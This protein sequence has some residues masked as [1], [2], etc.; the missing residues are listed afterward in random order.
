MSSEERYGIRKQPEES[1]PLIDSGLI[2]IRK[3]NDV[4]E[5]TYYALKDEDF[6]SAENYIGS[7]QDLL[8]GL[9]DSFQACRNSNI[10]IRLWGQEWKDKAKEVLEND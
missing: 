6:K 3:I 7:V 2:K 1:C 9:E 10:E 8:A 4:L 5:R